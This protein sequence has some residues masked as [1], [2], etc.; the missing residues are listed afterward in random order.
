MA[1]K[2]TS[3]TVG[4]PILGALVART[5]SIA[6]AENNTDLTL[7]PQGTGIAKVTKDLEISS[8]ASLRLS[9]GDDSNYI[10]LNAPALT[11]NITYTL[12]ASPTNGYYLQTDANGALSW[13]NATVSISNQEADT[14]PGYYVLMTTSSSGNINT[15]NTSASKLSY[16]PSQGKLTVDRAAIDA[17]AASNSTTTGSLVVTG[18]VGVS[19]QV[20]ATTL[21]ETS[22]AIFK[23][24]I[25]PLDN[26]LDSVMKLTGV[27]YDR[28]DNKEHEVGLIAEDVA[29]IL[30]DL[31][32][33]D[34][35]GNPYG[36]KYTK[37][38][39]YLIEA[40]KSLAKEIDSLKR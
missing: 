35:S 3:G 38:T 23:E 27:S 36:I 21:V 30:P 8:G 25:S 28:L 39:A 4:G 14:S 9:D 11:A 1:R 15:V 37:I 10:G 20:T 18:G 24:N 7:D 12:P 17:N 13:A 40:V 2:I 34:G 26:A 29:K 5:S 32:S 33:K 19:G 22:S 6:P 31:V 16:Q